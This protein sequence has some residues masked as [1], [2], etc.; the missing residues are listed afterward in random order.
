V[1][2]EVRRARLAAVK[3]LL[4]HTDL[5]L[6]E[7]ARQTGFCHAQHLNN[8]FRRAEQATPRAYR[9]GRAPLGEQAEAGRRENAHPGA[10]STHSPRAPLSD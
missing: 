6:A 8:V 4:T 2:D 3:R 5:A 10:P 1:H 9:T 7:I